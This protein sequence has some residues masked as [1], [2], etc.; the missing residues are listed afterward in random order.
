MAVFCARGTLLLGEPE[1]AS[2][3]ALGGSTTET[4]LSLA[5]GAEAG[6]SHPAATAILRAARARSIRPDGARSHNYKPGLG[7]TAVASG[8]QKLV[9]G[10]RALMLQE[11][12][13]VAAAE[14]AITDLEAVGRSTLLVALGGRLVGVVGLQDGLRPGARAAV[15]HLLDASVEP[16]LISGDARETCEAIGRALDV[17]HTRPEVLPSERA[18][19]IRRLADGGATIAVIGQSPTDDGALGAAD[20][21]V[22]LSSAGSPTAEWNVQL[23]SDDVRDAAYAV[24]IAHRVRSEGRRILLIAAAP[25]LLAG[26]CVA[27]ALLPPVAGPLA[28][29]VGGLAAL[30][31]QRGDSGQQG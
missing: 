17:E 30:A 25:G 27:F 11:R 28:A 23:A 2:V 13:S 4:V 6:A 3:E 22:A 31:S 10:S 26:L 18:E 8:G 12:I 7:V 16:V 9:V 29:L 1:V 21:S 24:Q 5:A 20:V 14:G 19:E 15:Q